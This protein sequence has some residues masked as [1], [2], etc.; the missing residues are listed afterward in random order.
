MGFFHG[1]ELFIAGRLK[2]LVIIRGANYYP[3]DI[4]LSVEQSD[5]RLRVGATAA[6]SIQ[7][8][9]REE[10]IVVAEVERNADDQFEDV[11]SAIRRNV[12]KVHEIAPDSVVLVRAGS[13]PKTTSGKIQ[14]KTCR[15]GYLQGNLNVVAAGGIDQIDQGD[16]GY[17]S[18]EDI[19]LS[20]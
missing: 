4:E 13:I 6:F 11:I 3:Q 18:I 5:P 1:E 19:Q 2:D 9:D 10:L 14:R 8:S 12:A 16:K 15:E 17:L 20:L 7:R